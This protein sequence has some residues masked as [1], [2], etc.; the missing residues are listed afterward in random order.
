VALAG[1]LADGPLGRL[2]RCAA[3]NSRTEASRLAFTSWSDPRS[4][5]TDVW[6]RCVNHYGM[7]HR[8]TQSVRLRQRHREAIARAH[9]PIVR[10]LPAWTALSAASSMRSVGRHHAR[11]AKRHSTIGAHQPQAFAAPRPPEWRKRHGCGRHNHTGA[12]PS[13]KSSSKL[14]CPI[15]A[16]RHIAAPGS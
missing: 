6:C 10:R 12:S 5:L 2:G 13:A 1:S 3:V 8:A 7:T 4:D 9:A 14:P 11:N 16:D 15:P